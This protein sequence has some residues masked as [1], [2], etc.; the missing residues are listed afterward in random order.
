MRRFLLA[1]I[2]FFF[3][4]GC[5]H[6]ISKDALRGVDMQI[7]YAALRKDAQASRGKSVL[8]GGVIVETVN[9]KNGTL[10]EIYQTGMDR[11]GKPIHP[12]SSE[13]RFLALYKGVL[14][15]EIYRKG[16]KVT[17]AG[18][19]QGEQIVRLGEIDYR[20]PYVLITDMHLWKEETPERYEPY[21]WGFWGPWWRHPWYPWH[22][23]YWRYR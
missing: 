19:V 22:D 15:K 6:V 20:Y 14:E 9:K 4:S 12:D 7:T 2:A 13:G 11:W 3:L 17:I 23:P 18:I 1:S 21:P 16:R 10:L 5:G 8:L